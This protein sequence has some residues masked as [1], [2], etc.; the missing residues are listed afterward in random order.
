[1]AKMNIP[2]IRNTAHAFYNCGATTVYGSLEETDSLMVI[3]GMVNL[4]FSIELNLKY[5]ILTK[6]HKKA[7]KITRD[8]DLNLL[9]FLLDNN[10][11][12]EIKNLT[13]EQ[14][15][16]NEALTKGKKYSKTQFDKDLIA[17]KDIFVK[18]R[19]IYEKMDRLKVPTIFFMNFAYV[20]NNYDI[21]KESASPS[22]NV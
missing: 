14:I 16:K 13:V 6:N 3:P 10:I 21:K 19:Y 4:A 1:M 5:L 18:W 22:S 12:K 17:V 2:V 8:H 7:K 11:R 9:S 20:V 15:N